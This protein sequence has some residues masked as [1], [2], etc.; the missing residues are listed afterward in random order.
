MG[1]DVLVKGTGEVNRGRGYENH[2][3][4]ITRTLE[5]EGS[6]EGGCQV[7]RELC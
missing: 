4:A 7:H 1:M 6:A 3:V 2:K 5:V